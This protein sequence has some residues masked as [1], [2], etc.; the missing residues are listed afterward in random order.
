ML[1]K[2]LKKDLRPPIQ[3]GEPYEIGVWH[4]CKNFDTAKS[5]LLGS[6]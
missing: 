4:H 1:V 6:M 5:A 2:V 3:G